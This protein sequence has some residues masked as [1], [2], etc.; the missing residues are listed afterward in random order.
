[1]AAP[2][3]VV[4]PEFTYFRGRVGLAA[5]LEALGIGGDDLVAIQAFTCL[6]V[7]E[8]VLAAK[9]LPLYVDVEP[10]GVNMDPG[11]L[12]KALRVH[13][14]VRA[15]VVQHTF[16]LPADIDRILEIAGRYSLPVIE[17]CAHTVASTVNG[18]LLGTFGVASF[19]SHEASKPV[20]AGLGGSVRVNDPDLN[21]RLQESFSQLRDP[22]PIE[23]GQ[24]ALMQVGYRVLYYPW[25]YWPIRRAFR[26]LVDLGVV[27]GN[28]NPTGAD[29]RRSRDFDLR[30]GGVQKRT[31]RHAW[32]HEK[33]RIA[34]RRA[35][36]DAYRT[37]IRNP[38]VR[39]AEVRAGMNPVFARYPLIVDHKSELMDAARKARIELADF[40]ATPVHPFRG[41]NL[42][43]V[44]YEVGTCPNAE[45][46]SRTVVSLPTSSRVSDRTIARVL[47]FFNEWRP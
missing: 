21:E 12:E 22:S 19:F 8:A 23:Q 29:L 20:F 3:L 14:R 45:T 40:Y 33:N 2:D 36:A 41:A 28:Y 31:L 10:G 13:T 43:Q 16:G 37:G 15:I 34:R 26:A 4:L 5:A 30:M 42:A 46:A 39:H 35:V 17:D 9:A 11:A 1:M 27:R 38:H 32:R 47:R 18:R 25:L 24:I 7:P 44:Y 6:A